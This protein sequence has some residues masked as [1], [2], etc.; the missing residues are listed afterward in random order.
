MGRERQRRRRRVV[1]VETGDTQSGDNS[2]TG[3][4]SQGGITVIQEES[5]ETGNTDVT[6]RQEPGG[7]T[8]AS[9]SRSNVGETTAGNNVTVLVNVQLPSLVA[10]EQPAQR[11]SSL[12]PTTQ[13]QI[14]AMEAHVNMIDVLSSP[15][16]NSQCTSHFSSGRPT[17]EDSGGDNL[18]DFLSPPPSNL[19]TSSDL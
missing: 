5:E 4:S 2:V 11:R 9:S 3:A 16:F 1:I 8:A 19:S 7:Q 15:P 6:L 12:T 10:S 18:I 17:S 14:E 13:Q